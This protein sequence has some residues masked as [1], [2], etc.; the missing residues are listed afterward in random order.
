MRE[1]ELREQAERD[2]EDMEKQLVHFREEAR[3]AHEALVRC[4]SF[5]PPQS[6]EGRKGGGKLNR[7]V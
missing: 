3:L 5:E 4:L 7:I 1:R 6:L 2:K